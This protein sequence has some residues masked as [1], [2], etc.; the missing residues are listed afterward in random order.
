MAQPTA[1]TSLSEM[2]KIATTFVIV[3]FTQTNSRTIPLKASPAGADEFFLYPLNFAELQIVL[4]RAIGKR[5]LEL[6]GR[7]LLQ[8]VESKAA[9]HGLIGGSAAMQKVYQAVEAVAAPAPSVVL[10]GESGV[11][12]ELSRTAIVQCGRPR[13]SPLRLPQLLR[14]PRNPDE[15]ELFRVR[16]GRFHRRRFRQA[17]HGRIGPQWHALPRR[18]TTLNP[19]LQSKLLRVLQ[20][21]SV[22]RLGSRVTRKIDF[23]LITATNE[24]L[25]DS[26]AKAASAKT[27]TSAST[28]CPSSFHRCATADGDIP[29]LVDHFLRVYAPPQKNPLKLFNPKSSKFSRTTRGPAMSAN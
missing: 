18:I 15:S 16:K 14:P 21:R 7:R 19:N 5:A 2:R 1:S 22:Q 29:L 17:R 3:A 25:E 6:E 10:R 9:F 27:S 8:Q 20:E 24:D 26:V 4:S 11:G 12:K 28:S 13:R 23:R